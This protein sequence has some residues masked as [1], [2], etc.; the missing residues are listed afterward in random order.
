MIPAPLMSEILREEFLEPLNITA[1]DIPIENIKAVLNGEA[2]IDKS[3][4]KNLASFFGVSDMFFFNLQN[5]I[6][7]RSSKRELRY[8]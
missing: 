2:E 7:A 3:M 1:D 5:D 8:A 4:S 6:K